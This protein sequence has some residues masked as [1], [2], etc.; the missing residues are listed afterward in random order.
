MSLLDTHPIS[1]AIR[2]LMTN[3]RKFTA[4]DVYNEA[5]KLGL[6]E[7]YRQCRDLIHGHELVREALD[8][9]V[10]EKVL[11]TV[12]GA[13]GKVPFVYQPVATA[14]TADD[15]YEIGDIN[16]DEEDDRWDERFDD[17]TF[18][19][20]AKAEHKYADILKNPNLDKPADD[21]LACDPPNACKTDKECWSH[22]D[23]AG[24]RPRTLAA[25]LTDATNEAVYPTVLGGLRLDYRGR[26]RIPAEVIKAAGFGSQIG[27]AAD[28]KKRRTYIM[29]P[30]C[31]QTPTNVETDGHLWLSVRL[32]E[33]AGFPMDPLSTFRIRKVTDGSETVLYIESET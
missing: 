23:W 27:L 8:L 20:A 31:V 2:H 15:D 9:G 25:R 14:V 28:A 6:L 22:S 13:N 18:G 21:S 3:E 16:D 26:L 4:F 33:T 1:Q 24:A 11:G 19:N 7:P 12:E 29:S 17:A 32:L 5:K 30:T 10:Y